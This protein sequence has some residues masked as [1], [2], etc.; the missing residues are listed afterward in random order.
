MSYPCLCAQKEP[1]A[2]VVSLEVALEVGV[3]TMVA[4]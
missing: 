3:L 4:L 1:V 2:V